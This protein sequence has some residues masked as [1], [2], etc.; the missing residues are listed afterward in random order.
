MKQDKELI[1]EVMK[2]FPEY[3]TC[4]SNQEIHIIKSDLKVFINKALS[5]ANNKIEE[6]EEVITDLRRLATF[7]EDKDLEKAMIKVKLSEYQKVYIGSCFERI[8]F[9]HRIQLQKQRDDMFKEII[10]LISREHIGVGLDWDKALSKAIGI[11]EHLK[12]K[13]KEQ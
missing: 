4:E 3:V 11:I 9:K 1:E 12:Q 8:N 6:L 10:R 2:E 13:H 7:D 5:S